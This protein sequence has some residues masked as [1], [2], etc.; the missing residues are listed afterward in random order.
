ML[1]RASLFFMLNDG[2]VMWYARSSP[3]W[4]EDVPKN[5]PMLHAACCTLHAACCTL[6]AALYVLR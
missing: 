6:Q 5:V 1:F 2:T 3:S 4:S